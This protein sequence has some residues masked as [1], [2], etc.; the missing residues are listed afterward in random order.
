MIEYY[1]E[2]SRLITVFPQR[3]PYVFHCLFPTQV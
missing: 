2:L 3:F 1:D